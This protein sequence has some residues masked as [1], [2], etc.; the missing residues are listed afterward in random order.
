MQQQTPL[1]PAPGRRGVS[2]ASQHSSSSSSS[3][4][5]L[6]SR[7]RESSVPRQ[8]EDRRISTVQNNLAALP[9]LSIRTQPAQSVSV[10]QLR[11]ARKQ[12]ESKTTTPKATTRRFDRDNLPSMI[13]A[14]AA[15]QPSNL[16][17]VVLASA[18]DSDQSD[19]SSICHS[20]T[21][22]DYGKKKKKDADARRKRLTKEP[23]PAAMEN[24]PH[25]PRTMSDPTLLNNHT[26]Q[27]LESLRSSQPSSAQTER[28]ALQLPTQSNGVETVETVARSPGFI[29]GVRLEREREAVKARLMNARTP[30]EERPASEMMLRTNHTQPSL[31]LTDLAT[32]RET[33]PATSYPPT[34]SKSPFLK[35]SSQPA[36]TRRGS[37]GQGLKAAAGKFF[38]SKDRESKIEQSFQKKNESQES[39]QTVQTWFSS[40]NGRGRQMSGDTLT[41][42]RGQSYDSH[43]RQV[44]QKEE[45]KGGIRLPPVTWKNRR[46]NR[47]TSMIAV[48]PDSARDGSFPHSSPEA[49]PGLMQDNFG[50]L[51]RPFSP[52]ADGELSPPGSL[53][54]SMK[55]KMSP[56]LTPTSATSPEPAPA[57]T[58]QPSSKKTFKDTLKAGFRTSYMTSEVRTARHRSGTNDTLV[59]TDTE[60]TLPCEG[61]PLQ[62]HPVARQSSKSSPA[63]TLK[64]PQRAEEQHTASPSRQG[65]SA[66]DPKDSGASSSSSHPDSESQPP[67]PMTTPD[68]SRPQSSSKDI[69]VQTLRIDDLRK[70]PLFSHDANSFA[71][72]YPGVT[73]LGEQSSGYF[74]NRKPESPRIHVDQPSAG[75]KQPVIRERKSFGPSLANGLPTDQRFLTDELWTRSKKP[76]D[77]DQLSFTSA[78]T[79][80]DV[81]RSFTELDAVVNSAPLQPPDEDVTPMSLDKTHNNA[82]TNVTAK[83]VKPEA[84][85]ASAGFKQPYGSDASSRAAS[86]GFL[87]TLSHQSLPPQANGRPAQAQS[88]GKDI[89]QRSVVSYT[90]N[91]SLESLVQSSKKAS[92]YLQEARKAA[93]SS[94]RAPA[95]KIS[96]HTSLPASNAT[97]LAGP[98]TFALTGAGP[99]Q[100]TSLCP[101]A[102]SSATSNSNNSTKNSDIL[103][104]P[105]AKMLVECCHCRF[106]HDMPSRVYEAMA[107]PDDVVKDKRLGV[108]G[109]VTTCVKCPW[110]SHNMST[111]CCAGYAA[112]VYLREKLHGP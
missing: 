34:S 98:R 77:P 81:K 39:V 17:M 56:Q 109:Q 11:P 93:P 33:A 10:T 27:S 70:M 18:D 5:S 2:P 106:Y 83:K 78:L 99:G 16:K 58:L 112:V 91:D 29:G 3:R 24:R 12:A 41:H 1:A 36:R 26:R 35:Q 64:G 110:C 65:P 73:A 21:W 47:T 54:A 105:M 20:P 82:K 19:S 49:S 88:S 100:P 45:K 6:L 4:P 102:V 80:L 104:K 79:S 71:V 87:A 67:S 9:P 40:S 89:D 63:L 53:S 30:S 22:D 68:T 43:E 37:F 84:A 95:S 103:G 31:E 42:S 44:V 62:S 51:E 46:Q 8:Q 76:L 23:P 86:G 101:T 13:K 57:P 25:I 38:N 61:Y 14:A 66:A 32:K 85:Q 60:A 111:V 75:P 50:F 48:P 55:A 108:S 69:Q 15:P 72:R 107:Q 52:P 94:P 74:P 96:S 90:Q 97:S 28:P 7:R 92:A 59:G